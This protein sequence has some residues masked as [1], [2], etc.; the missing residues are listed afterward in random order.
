MIK[1]LKNFIDGKPSESRTERWGDVYDP[2]LGGVASQVPM[3]TAAD[4]DAAVS[5]ARRAF[6][7]WSATPAPRRARVLFRFKALLDEHL[8]DLAW[9]LT[10]EHGKV[11]DDARGSV[12]RGMEVVEFAC[13]IPQL[14]KGEYSESVGRGV[15]CYSFR[16]PLGV[17]AGVGPFNFPA[18]IPL[19][20]G[21]VAIA[22]GNTF[23][24]KPSERVPSTA[25]RLAELWKEAGL[26]D[27]VF[28]IVN[29]D[30]E[31]VDALVEHPDVAAISLVGS[32]PTAESVYQRAT[33]ARKRV[34][35]L[36]G[37]KNHM[38]VMPDADLGQVVDALM[39]AAYGSAGERCMAISVAVVVGAE[40]GDR[41]IEALLPKVKGLR[42]GPGTEPGVEMGPLITKAHLERVAQYVETGQKEGAKL[43]VDG[44]GLRVA[45]HENGF[46]MGGCLFDGVTSA[47]KV[48][49]EE[50]FGPVLCVV[51]SPDLDSA[52]DLVNAHRYGNGGA[53]FTTSGEAADE[54]VKRI[55]I[56][57]VGVNV[58]IPVPM[59]FHS[60]GGWKGSLFGDHFMHGPEGVRFFTRLKTVTSRWPRGASTG[61]N[62]I[63]PTLR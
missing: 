48:Y 28:N 6:E 11:L 57:M 2:A 4:V 33:R 38:V 47:M 7:A 34:Q 44:R 41:L 58:P 17:C 32:T 40:T 25:F 43:L 46:F 12:T 30:K 35:A 52:I 62:F 54:F 16:Q 5:A 10:A 37:A 55:H 23:V 21:P 1:K 39:G 22:C 13:G 29:G 18:M 59:A 45:G 50:I 51:R 61:A 53:I 56:G 36:G 26:P 8:D 24:M 19:W 63:M 42:L 15:D 20:M 14:L 60:F 9:L 49:Q 31:V 27:G 3:S